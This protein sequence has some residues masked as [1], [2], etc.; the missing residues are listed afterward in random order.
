MPDERRNWT[1]DET[2]IAFNLYCKIPFSE[3]TKSNPL[4]IK[5]APMLNRTP[6]ALAMKIG[7]LASLDPQLK[8]RG[9]SGLVNSSKLDEEIWNEFNEDWNKLAFESERILAKLQDIDIDKVAIKDQQ[10]E[11]VFPAGTDRQ[12]IVKARVNQDF[13]RSAILT[14]YSSKCCITGLQVPQLLV[15][16]HIIPWSVRADLR[17]NPRNG[18]LLNAIH[19][20]AFDTGLITVTTDYKIKVSTHIGELMPDKLINE[21]F[22]AYSGVSIQLPERFPPSKE[23]L[24]WHNKNVFKN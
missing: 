7:N 17:T 21:W 11:M 2:I 12:A 5:F 13:F 15:A 3:T 18:L 1:R 14:A 8:A 19:D 10:D 20:K 16:S 9:I 22:A 4:I 6:S 23:Y 24:E